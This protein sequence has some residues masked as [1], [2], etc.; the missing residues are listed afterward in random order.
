MS[1]CGVFYRSSACFPS[2]ESVNDAGDSVLSI[3]CTRGHVSV[4]DYLR[5]DKGCDLDGEIT[6]LCTLVY[7]GCEEHSSPVYPITSP[8]HFL[9]Q[10]FVALPPTGSGSGDTI[11]RGWVSLS[12]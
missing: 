6:V 5:K 10:V 7:G 2:L 8:T 3:A 4:I 12:Y 9:F 11:N 1:T